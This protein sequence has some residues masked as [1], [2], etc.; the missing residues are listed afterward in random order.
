MDHFMHMPSLAIHCYCCVCG[1]YPGLLTP[2]FVTCITNT[3]EGLV[4]L[5]TCCDVP[6]L[7]VDVWRSGTFLKV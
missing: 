3:G 7:W 1:L 5:I 6:G 4:K 2:A